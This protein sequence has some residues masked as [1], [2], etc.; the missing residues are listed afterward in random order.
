MQNGE[1][2]DIIKVEIIN[3]LKVVRTTLVDISGFANLLAMSDVCVVDVPEEDKPAS[4]G[5]N[6]GMWPCYCFPS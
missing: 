3:L 6:M 4:I 5:G 1:C 2:V